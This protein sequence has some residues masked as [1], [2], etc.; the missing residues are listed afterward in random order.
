MENAEAEDAQRQHAMFFLDLATRANEGIN[1]PE[2][3]M[4]LDRQEI[5][6]DNCRAALGWARSGGDRNI[7]LQ[8]ASKIW[9]FWYMRGYLREGEEWLASL[10]AEGHDTPQQIRATALQG[11][12]GL[13]Y[14]QRKY[15]GAKGPYEEALRLNREQNNSHGIASSLGNLAMVYRAQ[16][17]YATA[18]ALQEQSL[19]LR[20]EMGDRRGV[21]TALLNLAAI[22]HVRGNLPEAQ[23]LCEEQLAIC[24]ELQDG[25]GIAIA[26]NNLGEVVFAQ[27]DIVRAESL[28]G[29]A[30]RI[31]QDLGIREVIFAAMDN[32]AYTSYTLEDQIRAVRL[33]ASAA[34]VR[35]A[36]GMTLYPG[37]VPRWEHRMSELREALGDAFMAAWDDAESWSEEVAVAYALRPTVPEL[38]EAALHISSDHRVESVLTVRE[39]QVAALIAGGLTNR[40]IAQHLGMADRTADTHVGKILRKLNLSSRTEIA[41]WVVSAGDS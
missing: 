10:L 15:D 28:F 22:A 12:G 36:I 32:L 9:M 13:L 39:R 37:E 6:H 27:G 23:R 20:Q 38:N 34:A 8:L 35:Q 7:G 1:S 29:E 14:A 3:K 33:H 40:Q 16:G 5:E 11:L 18:S 21:A 24:R 17:E 2:Q 19:A 30:L 4:W 41:H 25:S 31:S 26:L